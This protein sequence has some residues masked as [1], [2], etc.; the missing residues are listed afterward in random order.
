[1]KVEIVLRY[2][3]GLLFLSRTKVKVRMDFQSR[4]TLGNKAFQNND[5][6]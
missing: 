6:T 3:R 1:M 2:L 4:Q 5:E